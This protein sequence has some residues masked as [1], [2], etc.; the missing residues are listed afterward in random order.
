[1]YRNADPKLAAEL[2]KGDSAQR[3]DALFAYME[4]NGQSFYDEEVTQLQHALQAANQARQ[5]GAS[6]V[7]VA[8]ALLHDLGHFL[9]DEHGEND[10][11]LTED[12][13][14]EEMG[15]EYLEPFFAAAVTEPVKLHVPAKRYICSTDDGYYNTLS[16]ASK[17]SLELQGGVMSEEEKAEFEKNV[18]YESAV[19]LRKW[20]DL[21][22]VVGL[23][24]P[25]LES[26]REGVVGCLK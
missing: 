19:R 12:F 22:K 3:V 7:E 18:Y 25:G 16:R 15:A 10:D 17:R 4:E 21:A 13:F 8:A 14:H 20:D 23:E 2:S 24:V 9:V 5:A 11:F 26:Y 1:M 6:S